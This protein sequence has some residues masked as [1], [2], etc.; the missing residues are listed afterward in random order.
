[1]SA[2][3]QRQQVRLT[4]QFAHGKVLELLHAVLDAVEEL[5]AHFDYVFVSAPSG[6]RKQRGKRLHF[7]SVCAELIVRSITFSLKVTS[8]RLG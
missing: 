1:M 4:L 2:R 8:K 5:G 3:S 6:S 7:E